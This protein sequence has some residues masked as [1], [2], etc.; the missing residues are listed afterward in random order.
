MCAPPRSGGTSLFPGGPCL[1]E[2]QAAGTCHTHLQS[3]WRLLLEGQAS[4]R[5]THVHRVV[6]SL[7]R[8][9]DFG[10]SPLQPQLEGSG[11]Q[12]LDPNSLG[13]PPHPA[14]M[15]S[16][17]VPK[18]SLS[19]TEPGGWTGPLRQPGLRGRAVTV[20]AWV[21]GLPLGRTPPQQ[22]HARVASVCSHFLLLPTAPLSGSSRLMAVLQDGTR[23]PTV[24]ERLRLG[25]Q[26]PGL[27]FWPC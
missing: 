12:G 26:R 10:S 17:Q 18:A 27:S 6:V 2:A 16:V 25:D 14:W 9:G 21:G 13:T 24:S 22:C 3:P 7:S 8:T 20:Q 5:A 15:P 11:C 23:E 4:P 19:V 1:P